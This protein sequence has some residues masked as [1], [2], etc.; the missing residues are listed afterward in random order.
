MAKSKTDP[1]DK[2]EQL[3]AKNKEAKKGTAEIVSTPD[4]DMRQKL[5]KKFVNFYFIVLAL[6]IVGIPVYNFL[7]FA[8]THDTSLMISV[9]DALLTYSA[10]VG[11]TFGLVVAYYFKSKSNNQ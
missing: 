7:M 10:V 9:K 8:L 1:N 6:I 5:A 3:L 2:L 4:D 11:P